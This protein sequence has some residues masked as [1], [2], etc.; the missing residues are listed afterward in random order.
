MKRLGA[1]LLVI[2]LALSLGIPVFAK[3]ELN[4]EAESVSADFTVKS[5]SAI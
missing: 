4:Y 3:N 5:K 1:F 2:I